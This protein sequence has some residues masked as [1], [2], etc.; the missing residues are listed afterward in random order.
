MAFPTT[1]E[2][3]QD[4]KDLEGKEQ[5]GDLWKLCQLT[6]AK[7]E[8]LGPMDRHQKLKFIGVMI[9]RQPSRN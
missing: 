6:M 1:D 8:H 5:D 9:S 7:P 2:G 3:R 4:D